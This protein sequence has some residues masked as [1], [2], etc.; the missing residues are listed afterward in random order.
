[1]KFWDVRFYGENVRFTPKADIR[2]AVG[3]SALGQE[4][5]NPWETAGGFAMLG[6]SVL[7]ANMHKAIIAC[8]AFAF[9]LVVCAHARA[10][11]KKPPP[12]P[13][14]NKG[15]RGQNDEAQKFQQILNQLTTGQARTNPK[16]GTG[17]KG[18]P[19]G[20]KARK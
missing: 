8:L 12:P 3:M 13:P 16:P 18:V 10:E 17:P 14:P 4:R 11:E 19:A 20:T 5:T 2:S 15:E 1:V 9:S 6:V 7:G